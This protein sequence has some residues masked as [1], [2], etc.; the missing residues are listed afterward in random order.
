MFRRIFF[1]LIVPFWLYAEDI[2]IA[3]ASSLGEDAKGYALK[4]ADIIEEEL[5]IKLIRNFESKI[6]EDEAALYGVKNGLVKFVVVRRALFGELGLKMGGD[7]GFEKIGELGELVLLAQSIY[8]D[9][10]EREKRE[11][12]L[13][14]L[15]K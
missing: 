6:Y 5:G 15:K 10:L 2:K 3:V 9:S 7:Y 1:A 12:L 4:S 13:K 8:I 14:A 11:K